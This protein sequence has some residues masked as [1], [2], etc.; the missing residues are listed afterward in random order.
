MRIQALLV[1]VGAAAQV[2]TVTSVSAATLIE[3]SAADWR[4]RTGVTEASTPVEAWRALGFDA[5]GFTPAP[6]PFWYGDVLPGGT[7]IAGMQ[8]NYRC[9]FLRKTFVIGN[10][11][12]VGGLRLG[13]L[14]DDGFVAWINGV[15]VQRVNMSGA[16]GT[17]VS[18][19]TLAINATEPV[20]FASYTLANP[21]AYLVEG[22]NVLAVQVFQSDM[23]SSDLG[24][25]ASLESI[26]TETVPPTVAGVSPAP[27]STLTNLSELTVTF[28]EEV[29][30]V[31]STDLLLNGIAATSVTPLSPTAYRF[32]FVRP[33]YGAVAITWSPGAGITDVALPPNPF[34]AN[35]AGAT[36]SYTLEDRTPPGVAL[37][38]PAAGTSVKVLPSIIVQFSEPVV[39]VE[40]GDLL[41]NGSP[42]SGLVVVA[43]N[44]YLF[45][46]T[47]PATG[48]VQVAWAS[49]HGITDLATPANAFGG[50]SWTY[51]YDPNAADA[52]PYISEFMA[53][54]TR[55]L[56]DET[57]AYNDWIE[58][59]N[60]STVAV[61]L[62]GW[63]L[64]DAPGNPNKW[65]F[66]ATN[67]AGGSF[68]VV[69]ASGN[70]RRVPGARL[71]TSFV[72]SSSGEY[73]ALTRPDGSIA[74]AFRPVFPAQVPDVSYGYAQFP[75]GTGSLYNAGT[76]GVYFTRPTP[77]AANVGGATTPGPVIDEI[78]HTPQVPNENDDL[79]VTAR[80]RPSFNPVATVTM[81][82][83]V[84][85]SNEVTTAM[86]DDGQHGDGA[87][88][89]GVYGATIPAN[90]STNGQMIRYLI[91][92]TDVLANASRWP[93]FT[94]NTG[95]AE[96]LGTVVNPTYVT[97]KLPIFHLFV[98][99]GQLAA[100]DTEAAGKV[101]L[102][103]DG[104]LYDNV[105]MELRGNTSASQ[106]KKSHRF[107][108]N[109]EHL[110]RHL[111]GYPRIRKTSLMA[112]F[113]D[114]AYLRQ[115]LSFWLLDKMGVPSPFFYP[116]RA[117]MNGAFYALQYHN[118]VI[119]EEQVARMGYDPAGALYKAAGNVLPSESSTGVFQ[120]K[121]D[122]INDHSD[123][124]V[125]ARAIN[126]TNYPAGQP[127]NVSQRRAAA[128]DMLDIP[129]VIN[130]LAGARWCA[131]NDDVWANM[132][133]YRDVTNGVGDGMWRNI[134]F[135][136]NA[137]WGQRYG[138]ITPLDATNDTCKS[139]PL[140]GGSTVI[141][142]DGGSYNRIYDVVIAVPETR[143][144]LLRRMR[145]VLD[146]WVD[147]PGVAPESRLLETHVRYMTNLIW[148]EAFLDRAKW[149]YSTWT[150]SNKPLTNA[151]DELFNQFINPRRHHWGVVHSITNTAKP[152]GI[153]PTSNA[154]I[155]VSQPPG[156]VLPITAVEYNP[157]SGN[158]LQE[159]VCLTNPTPLAI[160]ISGW[161]LTGGIEF[162]FKQ[163]TI[164]PSNGVIYVSP[165]LAEFRK[166]TTG[167]R[168]GQGLFVVGPY[169]GQ[170]SARGE[171]LTLLNDLGQTNNSYSYPGTP[172][173]VQQF[174]RITEVM[175][176]PSAHPANADSQEFEYIELRNISD[177]VTLSLAGVHFINGVEFNFTGSSVTSLAPGARVLVVRNATAFAARYGA[178]LPVAGQFTGNLDN[179]GERLQLLDA[180]NEEVLD[181]SYNNSWYP[182]TDGLG[183][184]LVITSET[185]DPDSWGHRSQWRPSGSV[186]GAPGGSDPEPAAIAPIEITEALT[187]T[188]L[189]SVDQI[190]LYNPT[191]G[192]VSLAGWWL[193][194]DFFTPK[195]FLIPPGTVIN[196]GSYLVFSEADFNQPGSPTAFSLSSKGDEVY[197]F[198]GDGSN[199]TGYYQGYS[200]GAAANGVT[201][202]R[203][204]NSQSNVFFVA[205]Q[206]PTL[207]AP[208]SGLKIGPLVISE[209]NYRPVDLPG[210]VDNNVDEFVELEN[211]SAAA[212]RLFDPANPTNTW[213]VRGGIDFE[214]PT[215]VTIAA[216]GFALLV[217]FSPTDAAM[218]G[219]FRA[220]F[221]V[222]ANVPLFGPY[223]GQ[224][225]NSGE[226]I[227]LQKPE[228]PEA[229]DV[230]YVLVDEVEYGSR[231]PWPSAPDGVGPTLQR[232]VS[233]AFGND[234]TNWTG[235]GPTAG[236][237]YVAGGTPP[238][239]THQPAS[240]T[241][242]AGKSA[243]FSVTVSGSAPFFYQWRFN[244]QNIYGANSSIFTFQPVTPQDGGAYSCVIFNSA[245]STESSSVQL[246]VVYP[247]TITA[248]PADVKL[249]IKPDSLAAPTTNATFT[250]GAASTTPLR[251]QWYFNGNPIPGATATAYTVVDVKTTDYGQYVCAVTDDI[252]TVFTAPGTLYPMIRPTVVVPPVGQTVAVGSLF[253][254]SAT[255]SGFPPP[256]TNE[257]RRG[258]VP[259]GTTVTWD[260]NDVFAVQAVATA[261]TTSYRV[262]VKNIANSQPG[263]ASSQAAIVTVADTDGDGIADTVE[264]ALG[265]DPSNGADGLGDLDGDGMSNRAE[266]IAGTDPKNSASYLRI[267]Q[268]TVPGTA[269]VSVAAVS[270]HSYSVQYTDDLA[271][272]QWS[273]LADIVARAGDRVETITDPAWTAGRF[274]RVVA[275]GVGQ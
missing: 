37:L 148:D 4:W 227:R 226:T 97:S 7:Q 16:A 234:S 225:D 142:C 121:S 269:V 107:E 114:P 12:E 36:W 105:T 275:P 89:D 260:T 236:S 248:G 9:I 26:L 73:L 251:Y 3:R 68:M 161:K 145:T 38:T 228:L 5:S 152:I 11:T 164:V 245:G 6:A 29:T 32:G 126:E 120:K 111:P 13:A 67:L 108:F 104:E 174:L 136:M 81:R 51:V 140:Y 85:F 30:G 199:L 21:G 179:A 154:G 158:Q 119:D 176:N 254:L 43:P 86:F 23:A 175:Y 155:P 122:P 25:D 194:D 170:L 98:A 92:A 93:L 183:F 24:F 200:Y 266:V 224:L 221:N 153:T 127:T 162:T 213:R 263:A 28:S 238:T 182:T 274:Y 58:I 115:H 60:P 74:S 206:T 116:V 91:A 229:G 239:V 259:I 138:G 210:G 181:F 123:Y 217:N 184:S 252:D 249:F 193:S 215:N 47:P 273:K 124:Q 64:T 17:A 34:N 135:D 27:G 240:L 95:T 151:V 84:M 76:N 205:L 219:A 156:L 137:S 159:Y 272:G 20:P 166:R 257:W 106:S 178:G 41:I 72:L 69:F 160:D 198:S 40:A 268:S 211:V 1:A 237:A 186:N 209:I 52:T 167:P 197:L 196:P 173:A 48:Q 82:Y 101:A 35:G 241:A 8:N 201:F 50:G 270:N 150:A 125:L 99:Q 57:G 235:V 271:S 83:R 169:Q 222:P 250:V 255:Y 14:V 192:A 247:P 267:D 59:Y 177:S 147:E 49:S 33:A 132:S 79:I 218:A 230:P 143:Q 202:G 19:T 62:E 117:Q 261:T 131:E 78:T 118:D 70:N 157:S 190:E 45:N 262:V 203:Y 232:I 87:S 66:P 10:V 129:E 80:V 243:T 242:V 75:A 56:A 212:V 168:G 214:F 139:H 134:P 18:I 233:S 189:P 63:A 185:A 54:N 187:H 113:L 15:E 231:T 141:A 195:K 22:T 103:Y 102:F 128:F 223:G 133:I 264:L 31:D 220:R 130:Y 53:S 109:R 61:N 55:S 204:V 244:G 88:G 180:A 65:M 110:F 96:Y 265:L 112:E 71:H 171:R 246:T 208:N 216:N 163:G 42:A 144:M 258:S 90:L 44:E 39:G 149:G 253:G 100:I 46:F 94:T 2:F 207:G 188:D 146:R 165:R 77:G 256:F 191:A 172:S